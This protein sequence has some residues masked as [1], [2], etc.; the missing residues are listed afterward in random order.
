MASITA[1]EALLTEAL[2]MGVGSVPKG[3]E[4]SMTPADAIKNL[5]EGDPKEMLGG[6]LIGRGVALMAAMM[7]A[8]DALRPEHKL[9]RTKPLACK[10]RIDT[11]AKVYERMPTKVTP[12]QKRYYEAWVE[13]T[14][15]TVMTDHFCVIF[16]KRDENGPASAGPALGGQGDSALPTPAATG[17]STTAT[18][19]EEQC[20][21]PTAN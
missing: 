1:A 11:L 7:D 18:S 13:F 6:F 5:R 12:K 10:Q 19:E 20:Q 3:K 15:F 2:E 21:A 4:A 9:D 8:Y 16:S 14:V 17:G